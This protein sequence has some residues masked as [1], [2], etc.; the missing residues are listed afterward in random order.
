MNPRMTFQPYKDFTCL[1]LAAYMNQFDVFQFISKN[2]TNINPKMKKSRKDTPF[3]WAAACGHF[4]ICKFIIDA[5]EDVDPID[6]DNN[7][8]YIYARN[9]GHSDICIYIEQVRNQRNGVNWRSA[10]ETMLEAEGGWPYTNMAKYFPAKHND[11][12]Q[13]PKSPSCVIS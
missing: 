10:D 6:D 7:T 5:I 9:H 8:P 3:H 11:P 13:S 2:V 1:H 12:V 4:E